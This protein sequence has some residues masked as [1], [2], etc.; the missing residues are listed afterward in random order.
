MSRT[1]SLT[2]LTA[3]YAEETGEVT[4]VLLTIDSPDLGAP[5][6]LSSDNVDTTS[7]GNVYQSFPFSASLPGDEPGESRNLQ[8]SVDNVDR[9]IANAL[10]S[11]RQG[12]TVKM[13]VIV[14]S[15]PD[16]VQAEFDFDVISASYGDTD[17]S[18]TLSFD[19]LLD[20]QFP[21]DRFTPANAPGLF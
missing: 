17:A 2:A 9:Q 19:N 16:A 20:E 18:L 8:L 10:R 4:L 6:R 3:A 12:I 21:S 1:L 5:I 14:A 7:R 11:S 15:E 13:E